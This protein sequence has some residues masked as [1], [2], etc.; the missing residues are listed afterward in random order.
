MSKAGGRQRSR[1]VAAV[2]LIGGVTLILA[3]AWFTRPRRTPD[4]ADAAVTA[5]KVQSQ[6]PGRDIED[7]SAPIEPRVERNDPEAERPEDPPADPRSTSPSIPGTAP[8]DAEESPQNGSASAET[9]PP[10]VGGQQVG[11]SPEIDTTSTNAPKSC[12]LGHAIRL[13]VDGSASMRGFFERRLKGA[14]LRDLVG[15]LRTRLTAVTRAETRLDHHLE[16]YFVGGFD[17]AGNPPKAPRAS[18]ALNTHCA[19]RTIC[20]ENPDRPGGEFECL[21]ATACG[22]VRGFGANRM[23]SQKSYTA[24]ASRVARGLELLFDDCVSAAIFATDGL[25]TPAN[26]NM[27][28][29]RPNSRPPSSSSVILDLLRANAAKDGGDWGLWVLR[30]LVPFRGRVFLECGYA[31]A[32]MTQTL[33]RRVRGGGGTA[34]VHFETRG[35]ELQPLV[36]FVAVRADRFSLAGPIANALS[37]EIQTFLSEAGPAKSRGPDD[38][39]V[40]VFQVWPPN[41]LNP[42]N[43]MQAEVWGVHDSGR[44]HRYDGPE[45]PRHQYATIRLDGRPAGARPSFF[46]SLFE[47]SEPEP[48]LRVDGFNARSSATFYHPLDGHP[49]AFLPNRPA[50]RSALAMASVPLKCSERARKVGAGVFEPIPRGADAGADSTVRDVLVD[51]DCIAKRAPLALGSYVSN[52]SA[53]LASMAS[54]DRLSSE[55]ARLAAAIRQARRRLAEPIEV[56]A[57]LRCEPRRSTSA[58][59]ALDKLE[60]RRFTQPQQLRG[61]P[62][63]SKLVDEIGKWVAETQPA[64]LHS[65]M[66]TRSLRR[67]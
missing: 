16:R 63:M 36:L 24:K 27:A 12:E 53:R 37:D 56:T 34:E 40:E 58:L 4:L 35:Q 62:G 26:V 32:E 45:L 6:S 14:T 50:S 3:A 51:T 65:P 23:N 46:R 30:A 61:I 17:R 54:S 47:F 48:V 19:G 2:T 49:G 39:L 42:C 41:D 20:C 52:A 64:P 7:K 15:G 11:A 55:G 33:G 21:P 8:R 13:I 10:N 31:D 29:C 22:D 60:G 25:E 5:V 57:G 59:G 66:S 43:K 9:V 1:R 28:S 67:N 44:L 38:P 18:C